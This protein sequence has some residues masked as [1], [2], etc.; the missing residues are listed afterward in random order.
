MREGSACHRL[1]AKKAYDLQRNDMGL[2]NDWTF[3]YNCFDRWL[4]G[5]RYLYRLA[6]A[7]SNM[8]ENNRNARKNLFDAKCMAFKEEIGSV[9]LKGIDGLK[10][11]LDQ[12]VGLCHRARY[13]RFRQQVKE[14]VNDVKIVCDG[15]TNLNLDEG[16]RDYKNIDKELQ[17]TWTELTNDIFFEF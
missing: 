13:H 10:K 5:A 11:R 16:I 2:R 17:E 8:N 15:T 6:D 9:L 12:C 7:T 3:G 4:D 14:R 1:A